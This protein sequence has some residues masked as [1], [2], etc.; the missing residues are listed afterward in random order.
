MFHPRHVV[1]ITRTFLASSPAL[2]AD[3]RT[4]KFIFDTTR[5]FGEQSRGRHAL[6]IDSIG[7]LVQPSMSA[8]LWSGSICKICLQKGDWRNRRCTAPHRVHAPHSPRHPEC[9]ECDASQL[10]CWQTSRTQPQARAQP[11]ARTHPP[12]Q[13]PDEIVR[14][15]SSGP[16][17]PSYLSRRA[18]EMSVLSVGACAML[19]GENDFPNP[20]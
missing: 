11:R 17:V 20:W 2:Y 13:P 1:S 9:S 16:S 19:F 15:Q 8:E 7:G 18:F 10:C 4:A 3:E 6:G 14:V 5:V 12:A